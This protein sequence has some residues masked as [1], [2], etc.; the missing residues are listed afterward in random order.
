MKTLS[1][2]LILA[3]LATLFALPAFAQVPAASPAAAAG[4][5]EEAAKGELYKQYYDVRK[6]DQP[7]AYDFGKQYLAKYEACPDNYTTSV[8]KFVT[9]YEKATLRIDFFNAYNAKDVAKTNGLAQRLL[10]NDPNDTA[11]ALL[12]GWGTYQGTIAKNGAAT[13]ADALAFANRA[14]SLIESG[15]EPKDLGGKVSWAPFATKE[16]ALSY[17]NFQVAALQL[18]TNTDESVKRLIKVAQSNG[19]AKEEPSVYSFLA[20]AYEKE[21]EPMLAKYKTFTTE[22]DESKLLYANINQVIDRMIDAYARA[23][24]FSK[25]GPQ[26][27]EFTKRLTELYKSRHNNAD[28]GLSEYVARIKSQPLLITQPLTVLPAATPATNGTGDGA[29]ATTTGAMATP[30]ASPGV[31]TTTTKT[32]VTTTTAK[33]VVTNTTAKPAMTIPPQ[34]KPAAPAKKKP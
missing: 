27:T 19:K 34:P 15:Q 25:D 9:A 16:D 33:P 1:R 11:V 18:K 7:K 14:L 26:K 17:L 24:A 28:A 30:S 20:F 3:A 23:V 31:T 5:C 2:L 32:V 13:E 10:A 29:M 22:T 12:A 21:V 4:P 8:K 6:T